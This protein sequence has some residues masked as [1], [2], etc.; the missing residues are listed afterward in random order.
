[1]K[2]FLVAFLVVLIG[3]L[4]PTSALAQDLSHSVTKISAVNRWQNEGLMTQQNALKAKAEVLKEAASLSGRQTIT[5]EELINYRSIGAVLNVSQL[6]WYLGGSLVG[7]AIIWIFKEQVLKLLKQIPLLVWETLLYATSLGALLQNQFPIATIPAA[8]VLFGTFR[9]T[10]K[11]HW[12]SKSASNGDVSTYY[13]LIV[14]AI[15]TIV[16][17]ISAILNGSMYLGG[18]SALGLDALGFLLIYT[19]LSVVGNLTEEQ[20]WRP[21]T[22]GMAIYSLACCA[23][24]LSFGGGV[25]LLPISIA[26]FS[27]YLFSIAALSLRY[28]P[29][30]N[31]RFLV[32]YQVACVAS[33]ILGVYLGSILGLNWMVM[34][35]GVFAVVYTVVK[36][37]EYCWNKTYW[38]VSMGGLGLLLLGASLVLQNWFI[39]FLIK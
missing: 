3:L 4:L 26:C 24:S 37:L 29:D 34:S 22:L 28:W 17:G 10:W 19:L 25:L 6:F 18:M 39:P 21:I 7:L 20:K 31:V 13:F 12:K 16:Y 33:A 27:S 30:K 14:S 23:I 35:S 32:V 1:M 5:E 38:Y 8:F 11:W 2:R 9:F 36:Y 15:S